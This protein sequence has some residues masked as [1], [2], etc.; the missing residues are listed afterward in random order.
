MSGPLASGSLG[1]LPKW[2]VP[3]QGQNFWGPAPSDEEGTQTEVCT[4]AVTY[5][6]SW[7]ETDLSTKSPLN[8]ALGK[9]SLGE[10]WSVGPSSSD[11]WEGFMGGGDSYCP[12]S[13]PPS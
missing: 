3:G 8:Q 1:C 13:D 11:C 2:H 10:S 12:G 9:R 4:V 5:C 6:R 7:W